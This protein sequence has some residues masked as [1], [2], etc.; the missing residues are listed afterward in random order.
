MPV[1]LGREHQVDAQVKA[2]RKGTADSPAR[3]PRG[4][5]VRRTEASQQGSRIAAAVA[6]VQVRHGAVGDSHYN[7]P[8]LATDRQHAE[9]EDAALAAGLG[10]PTFCMQSPLGQGVDQGR[11]FTQ[12]AI[13]AES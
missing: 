4:L 9:I 13:L 1:E 7:M 3:F 5:P 6:Q 2:P 8:R 11:N 12:V 10:N